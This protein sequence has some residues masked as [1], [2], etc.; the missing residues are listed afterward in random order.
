MKKRIHIKDDF[1][2]LLDYQQWLKESFANLSEKNAMYL[3]RFSRETFDSIIKSREGWFGTQV[4]YEEMEDGVK[5]YMNPELLDSMYQKVQSEV[6]STLTHQLKARKLTFNAQG[7]GMF[8]FDR[9]A[10]TLY[11]NREYYSETQQRVVMPVEVVRSGKHHSLRSDGSLVKERWEQTEEGKPKVRTHTKE[12]FAFFPMVKRERPAVEFFIS[13]TA[14]AS[15][16]GINLLY[17]GISAVI[18]AEILTK[19]G[20]KIKINMMIGTA[21]SES[22]KDL[23]G[24][25]V[26][27]K[28]YDETMD[29]NLLALMSSDPRFM[30][31]DAFKGLVSV[32]DHF[33]K[34]IS[35]GF[36]FSLSA[37]ELKDILESSGYTAKLQSTYRYYFGGIYS[38]EAA[39]NNITRTIQEISDN[40]QP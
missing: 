4:T 2:G 6:V 23:V 1:K 5:E 35:S 21:I 8:C 15:V 17:N 25:I 3:Q 12:V 16:N 9:A 20:I 36:G 30:R 34:T 22:K 18:M 39:I 11:R 38:E 24:C 10:M 13:C 32:Y 14:P 26:P 19:A 31:Y 37:I 40:L 27:V 29:R 28:H 33:D 7:F